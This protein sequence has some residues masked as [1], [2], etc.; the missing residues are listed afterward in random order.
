M[1]CSDSTSHISPLQV[2]HKHMIIEA[3][4]ACVNQYCFY[5]LRL[6]TVKLFNKTLTIKSYTG[7]CEVSD[8]PYR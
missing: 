6:N 8:T 4:H 5:T 2:T 3:P 1:H 7:V